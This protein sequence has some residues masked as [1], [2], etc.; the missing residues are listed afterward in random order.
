MQ[1]IKH[2]FKQTFEELHVFIGTNLVQTKS[3]QVFK[4][5]KKLNATSLEILIYIVQI[6]TTS[7]QDICA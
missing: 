5:K 6:F 2:C 3:K 4:K 7:Q 1:K